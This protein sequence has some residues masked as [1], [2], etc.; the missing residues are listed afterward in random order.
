MKAINFQLD[1]TPDPFAA[2]YRVGEF[3]FN[4]LKNDGRFY[5][6]LRRDH[7]FT[8]EGSTPQKAIARLLLMCISSLTCEEELPGKHK[9]YNNIM[10]LNEAILRNEKTLWTEGI[11]V[12]IIERA[13]HWE[14]QLNTKEV[15]ETG[16]TATEAIGNLLLGRA[17]LIKV[18]EL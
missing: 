12:T 16:K 13:D 6:V 7:G 2:T 11:K 10:I 8:H 4:L 3:E 5:A 17:E 1:T 15:Y 9:S 14:A 18:I